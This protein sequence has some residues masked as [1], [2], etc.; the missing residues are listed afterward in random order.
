MI[1]ILIWL[2]IFHV[3]VF[4]F[5]TSCLLP[6]WI[7][8]KT[9]GTKIFSRLGEWWNFYLFYLKLTKA[10]HFNWVHPLRILQTQTKKKTHYLLFIV[11]KKDNESMVFKNKQIYKHFLHSFALNECVIV[12]T[13]SGGKLILS[14]NRKI[15]VFVMNFELYE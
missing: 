6:Q 11:N 2:F 5:E 15:S 10:N 13:S 7:L 3:D 12:R 9:T 1:S 8:I 14:T 4:K